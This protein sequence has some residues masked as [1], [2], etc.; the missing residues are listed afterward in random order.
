M[1]PAVAFQSMDSR[2]YWNRTQVIYGTS[3][4]W[5]A[6]IP[7]YLVLYGNG[8]AV[9]IVLFDF[10]KAFDLMDH[11]VLVGKLLE[12]E[13]LIRDRVM[14]CGHSDEPQTKS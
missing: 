11:R 3:L 12:Y 1:K 7:G 4:N 6:C 13:F 9:R 10:R 2:Q 8:A 14:D 5:Y